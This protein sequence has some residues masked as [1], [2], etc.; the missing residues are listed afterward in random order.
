[1]E[2]GGHFSGINRKVQI[3]PTAWGSTAE[4][5]SATGTSDAST[6][7][8]P[9]PNGPALAV[10]T[11]LPAIDTAGAL[12]PANA[13]TASEDVREALLVLK[14]GGELTED[15]VA[16]AEQLGH[17]FRADFY[18]GACGHAAPLTRREP[19]LT[20]SAHYT[21]AGQ[22]GLLRL[23]STYRH[24]LKIYAS[25]EGRVQMTAAAFAK[26]GPGPG[27]DRPC[28]ALWLTGG[29]WGRTHEHTG[30]LGS[31]RRAAADPRQ[32]RRQ[33]RIARAGA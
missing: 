26:V 30:L 11:P 7:A 10:A 18:P 16:Q 1:M 19:G 2:K 31:G 32:P 15:G 3:K 29:K 23:H 33:G 9:H 20:M 14:W 6:P 13:T 22:D 8:R 24:D 28:Q 12:D 5:A 25:D 4:P 27:P 17:R 21:D